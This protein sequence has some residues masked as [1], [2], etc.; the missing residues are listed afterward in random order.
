MSRPAQGAAPVVKVIATNRKA[1]HEFHI[2]ERLEAGLVLVGSEVKSLRDGKAV[3][4]DGWAAIEKGEGWLYGVQINEYPWA[5]RWNHDV[6]RKRKL[7]LSRT[8]LGKLGTRTR[9]RGFTLIPLSL[10]WKGPHVKVELGLCTHKKLHDK[11]EAKRAAD[12]QREIDRAIK[13]GR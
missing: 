9:E 1:S 6:K 10:Y 5:N 8:E 12:D 4:A 7:L 3:I 13:R 2:H 11:R